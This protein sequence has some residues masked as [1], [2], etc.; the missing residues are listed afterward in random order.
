MANL[1]V[2]VATAGVGFLIGGPTGASV[3]W[4]IGSSFSASKQRIEG[5]QTVGDL[6]VQTSQYGISIPYVIGRQRIAGNIIW[7]SD[8]RAYNIET[9]TGKGGG[10]VR[11][12]TGYKLDFA[13]LLCKG[14][15]IGVS[16]VWSNNKLI[17]DGRTE[18][19]PLVGTLYTGTE[20]QTPDPTMETSLGVGNVPAYRGLA[21]IVLS[22]FDLGQSG[23]VPNFSFE[24]I[25][26]GGFSS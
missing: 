1:I 5:Q 14:P 4:M 16:R 13:I 20:N 7:A 11:V 9:R 25:G 12:S 19:K 3:G 18:A 22:D 8:K 15:I 24:V 10:P 17:I 6:R 21:Y 23:A 26:A 2:P